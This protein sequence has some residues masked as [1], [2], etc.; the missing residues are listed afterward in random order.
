M[1][2]H[3]PDESMKFNTAG[4]VVLLAAALTG[5]EHPTET[6]TLPAASISA[7]QLTQMQSPSVL[8]VDLDAEW[9]R[10]ARTQVHGFVGYWRSGDGAY[11]VAI[12]PPG[13][14]RQAEEFVRQSLATRG[15]LASVRSRSV[16]FSFDQLYEW[17]TQLS[18]LLLNPSIYWVDIDETANQLVFGVESLRVQDEILQAV[19][20]VHALPAAISVI[21]SQLP[22]ERTTLQDYFRPVPGG[23]QIVSTAGTCTLGFNATRWSISGFITAAHC[24]TTKFSTD[25]TVQNQNGSTL[26]I[27]VEYSD[28]STPRRSDASMYQ[29]D[30]GVAPDWGHLARTTYASVNSRGSSTIDGLKPTFRITTKASNGVHLVGELVNKMGRTSGWTQGQVLRTCV[31]LGSLPCQWEARVWSEPGDSGSP[32]FQQTGPLEPEAG[33]ISMWGVLWGGP[34]NDWTTTWYAPIS[35]VEQDLGSLNFTCDPNASSC[36]PPPYATISGY[37]TIKR[38][39]EYTYTVTPYH[40]D[41]SYTYAWE[42]C[43]YWGQNCY[44]L[45]NGTSVTLYFQSGDP[46]TQLRV[47]VTSAGQ[48]YIDQMQINVLF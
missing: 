39:G 30:A 38:Q 46:I 40:G 2:I 31:S 8:E 12:A 41:G 26:R 1:L 5:C 42:R 25:G 3:I 17:K 22:V 43:D 20:A 4:L 29:Y 37:P 9:A 32:M 11:I 7:S 15:Q 47:A 28:P 13:D 35:A 18:S 24:S 10:I 21:E 23:V 36:I 45:G 27:G 19:T 14:A 16:I 48:T 6:S 34:V 44:G 33:R